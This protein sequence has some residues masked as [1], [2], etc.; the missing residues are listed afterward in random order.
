MRQAAGT[1]RVASSPGRREAAEGGAVDSL[2]GRGLLS[3]SGPWAPHGEVGAAG[4]GTRCDRLGDPGDRGRAPL[5]NAPGG[6]TPAPQP[7]R[8]GRPPGHK[9]QSSWPRPA[10]RGPSPSCRPVK[11][12]ARR[13]G[14][15]RGWR[16]GVERCGKAGDFSPDGPLPIPLLCSPAQALF[17]EVQ[18]PLLT[19]VSAPGGILWRHPPPPLPPTFGDFLSSLV[20]SDTALA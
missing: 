16:D 6:Q 20:S 17:R 5:D 15:G 19:L 8:H 4:G 7:A 9:G 1:T 13:R 3:T 2:A 14:G 18:F 10:P 12:S 11:D